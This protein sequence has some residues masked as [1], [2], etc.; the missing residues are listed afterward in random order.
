[1][2]TFLVTIQVI[3][4]RETLLSATGRDVAY[5]RSGMSKFMLPIFN[6][7]QSLYG[8]NGVILEIRLIL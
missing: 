8:Y 4:G 3:L 7:S 6:Q 5:E 1:M 2:H